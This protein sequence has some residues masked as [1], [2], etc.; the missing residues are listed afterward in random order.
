MSHKI[1]DKTQ[2]V[3]SGDSF[4]TKILMRDLRFLIFWNVTQR[5][6]AITY[7]RFGTAY[8]A[9]LEGQNSILLGM[10]TLEGRTDRLSRNVDN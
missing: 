10:L 7:R 4:R 6:L 5:W 2:A 8:M 1:H 3:L 9:H